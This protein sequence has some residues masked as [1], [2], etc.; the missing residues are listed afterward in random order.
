MSN[1]NTSE[2]HTRKNSS[3]RST[4]R[5]VLISCSTLIVIWVVVVC[6]FIYLI[7]SAN[8]NLILFPGFLGD[9][10]DIQ[11]V[12]DLFKF[13]ASAKPFTAPK[14][15]YS[16]KN[17]YYLFGS[18]NH[19]ISLYYPS[20]HFVEDDNYSVTVTTFDD[21]IDSSYSEISM[22]IID[23][24]KL[25]DVKTFENTTVGEVKSFDTE[26][27]VINGF[28]GFDYGESAYRQKANIEGKN[29][30][31]KTYKSKYT[32]D[33]ESELVKGC[34]NT[35][36]YNYDTIF[37]NYKFFAT[38]G[39]YTGKACDP[40]TGSASLDQKPD[41]H[42]FDLTYSILNSIKYQNNQKELKTF[43]D[44]N[45]YSNYAEKLNNLSKDINVGI[46][47]DIYPDSFRSEMTRYEWDKTNF[48]DNF[49]SAITKNTLSL[50]YNEIS[51]YPKSYFKKVGIK[52]F[53]FVKNLK[54][55]FLKRELAGLSVPEKN[56]IF[57]DM[58]NINTK[59][60]FPGTFHHELMHIFD[61][62]LDYDDVVDNNNYWDIL[63]ESGDYVGEDKIS[64][65][66]T[67]YATNNYTVRG[68]ATGYGK[69]EIFEDRAEVYRFLMNATDY[70]YA[71]YKSR[72]DIQ[73]SKKLERIKS[74]VKKYAP[75]M[76]DE[77]F[78]SIQYLD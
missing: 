20:T 12:N 69:T 49:D 51:K 77:Y 10:G 37:L 65:N 40:I 56:V 23:L 42:E 9:K 1:D 14:D 70:K 17:Y 45:T 46:Y 76:N 43:K 68:F 60:F 41:E 4:L 35:G 66:E 2:D 53:A 16:K 61:F 26:S 52:S 58:T 33:N 72:N 59:E 78:K 3:K 36:N 21:A 50:L 64:G 11:L 55:P 73:F 15:D 6:V 5:Y 48:K 47:F 71:I 67:L 75:E 38:I 27:Y 30:D 22:R 57:F 28:S 32:F 18:S 29:Y 25:K 19:G 54:E 44:I 7:Y 34:R 63:N 24:E 8:T 31:I 74:Q 13:D 62:N 39:Y